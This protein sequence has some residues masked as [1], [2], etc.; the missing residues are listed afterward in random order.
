M[1]CVPMS[2]LS[3]ATSA[4][5]RLVPSMRKTSF[6]VRTQAAYAFPVPASP[7]DRRKHLVGHLRKAS[8]RSLVIIIFTSLQGDHR[9]RRPANP[10]AA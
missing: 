4:T 7:P 2:H 1:A 5:K 10:I 8:T 3:D 6:L 9:F